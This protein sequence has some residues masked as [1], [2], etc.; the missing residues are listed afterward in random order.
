MGSNGPIQYHWQF[1]SSA[2]IGSFNLIG[3]FSLE[4]CWPIQCHRQPF[5]S[6]TMGPFNIIGNVSH[7]Q[8]W[9]N[10]LS[11][12]A[13]LMSN[14][15]SNNG[16]INCHHGQ[17]WAHSLLSGIFPRATMG[18]FN[19]TNGILME[20]NGAIHYHWQLFC[21][22]QLAHSILLTMFSLSNNLPIISHMQPFP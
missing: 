20:Q 9:A 2:A 1:L 10:S 13:S 14:N 5:L 6:A 18:P 16:T 7:G 21:W 8:Q 19:L 11:S 17:R 4:Q 3:N 22:Q 15:M 12:G